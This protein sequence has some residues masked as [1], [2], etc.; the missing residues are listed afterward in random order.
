M[1]KHEMAE[2]QCLGTCHPVG[3]ALSR[4]ARFAGRSLEPE[5]TPSVLSDSGLLPEGCCEEVC[6]DT[7]H[8]AA[9][10]LAVAVHHQDRRRLFLYLRLALH[11]G[12]LSGE[13]F[14]F[15]NFFKH[16]ERGGLCFER[17]KKKGAGRG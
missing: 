5:L 12:R 7:V 6:G 16:N 17:E 15:H 11:P 4:F 2:L 1:V 9:S 3:H 8:S 13:G 10:H 14:L